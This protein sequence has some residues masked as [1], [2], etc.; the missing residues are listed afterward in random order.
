[1]KSKKSQLGAILTWFIAF[2]IIFFIMIIFISGTIL[3]SARKKITVGSDEINIEEQRGRLETQRHA[4]RLLDSKVDDVR[5]SDYILDKKK[6]DGTLNSHFSDFFKERGFHVDA[7]LI[8]YENG[9]IVSYIHLGRSNDDGRKLQCTIDTVGFKFFNVDENEKISP[10]EFIVCRGFWE[11]YKARED[12][13]KNF[14]KIL[15][16]NPDLMMAL[17]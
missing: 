11:T 5:V 8:E 10:I 7:R 17:P 15:M 1:M 3:I 12:A 4:F 14:E 13:R 2:L 9:K 16:D 6:E